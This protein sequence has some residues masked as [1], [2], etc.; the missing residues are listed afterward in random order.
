MRHSQIIFCSAYFRLADLDLHEHQY[1]WRH[2]IRASEITVCDCN[3]KLTLQK[4]QKGGEWINDYKHYIKRYLCQIFHN[5][6]NRFFFQPVTDMKICCV[7]E[8]WVSLSRHSGRGVSGSCSGR[9]VSGSCRAA[10]ARNRKLA[11]QRAVAVE[12]PKRRKKRRKNR[13]DF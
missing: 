4:N 7:L 11:Q 8:S 13:E 6:F 3:L 12:R 10:E 2:S 5:L 1:P 9:G